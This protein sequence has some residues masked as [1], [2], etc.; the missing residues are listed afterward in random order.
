[1][2]GSKYY[3]PDWEEVRETVIEDDGEQCVICF[4]DD[5]L[6]VHHRIPFKEFDS[7]EE[8]NKSENLATLCRRCHQRIETLQNPHTRRGMP[9][10]S[11]ELASEGVDVP[12]E[13]IEYL[14]YQEVG[15]SAPDLPCCPSDD[16]F[17]PVDHKYGTCPKCGAWL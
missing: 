2:P 1:M 8:A 5:N 3:G 9:H 17:Y 15:C 12:E 13:F 6:Q 7:H 14:C 11:E 4:S 10:F 16:C